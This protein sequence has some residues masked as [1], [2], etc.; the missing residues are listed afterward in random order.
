MFRFLHL[1]IAASVVP[2]DVVSAVAQVGAAQAVAAQ[3]DV[4]QADVSDVSQAVVATVA[5]VATAASATDKGSPADLKPASN[6]YAAQAAAQLADA[7]STVV[8]HGTSGYG[9][10]MQYA[11][12]TN[13]TGV[14]NVEGVSPFGL[15]LASS[16]NSAHVGCV[17]ALASQVT[18]AHSAVVD[19]G[20]SPSDQ[21]AL[22][23]GHRERRSCFA[24]CIYCN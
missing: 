23:E 7:H 9:T 21:Q 8:D 10:A 13:S 16:T 1:D 3:A 14:L 22:G 6:M 18:A 24:S 17:Q 11:R 12:Y 15:Q 19:H 4:S 5:A 20:V 2:V